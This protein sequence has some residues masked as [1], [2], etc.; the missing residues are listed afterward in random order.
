MTEHY[1]LT[2]DRQWL[3]QQL[4]RLKAAADWILQ[5][6]RATM[7]TD[8]TPD[9]IA[10][11]EAGTWS[12]YGLQPKV[13]MGDGDPS[14]SRYYYWADAFGYRSVK[15]FS[16][17]VADLDPKLGAEYAAEVE[18]YRQD[19]LP[20]LEQSIVRSPVIRVRDGT[21]R[22]FHPQGF[23][24]RGPLAQ[25][26]PAGANIYSH[27]GP[28]H[29]DYC[30]TAAAIE[31]WLRS[32]L[33]AIDDVRLDGHFDVLEDDFLVDHPWVRKRRPD[34]DPQR[35][36]FDFGWSYQSGW[37]R[38]P[39]YYLRKDDVPN[40]LRAWLNRCAVD[41]NLTDYSFNEH[42][43]F[44][45]NDKSHGVAVFLSNFRNMLAME[46]GD[47]LWLARAT[48]RAWLGQGQRIS[49]RHAPT[50]FG[51]L[52]YEIVSDVD[53]GK[54]TASL[55]LPSRKV[56]QAVYLRL[57]HPQAQG[58]KT[59]TVNGQPWPRFDREKEFVN[60]TG[61]QGTVRVLAEYDLGPAR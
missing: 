33:L 7:K 56:P 35:D 44:A 28:Y 11:I 32:G 43:T 26:L 31:A 24:D 45:E 34:Y 19:I 40:F 60:L 39:E 53:H 48:P 2:G 10:G 1:R 6:R 5:R 51:T 37:E 42:T 21:S 15:L 41:L 12:R 4:P 22:S 20:V 36:W 50:H 9:E 46:M 3:Q 58:I 18:K 8:L 52:A 23:Q 59:V 38:L 55:E 47:Q 61:L 13:S 49:V 54:I 14:G 27:C 16:E 57:R 17:V 30:L 25:A 29:A